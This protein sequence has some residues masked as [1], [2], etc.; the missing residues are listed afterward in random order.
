MTSLP[1]PAGQYHTPYV[2]H[3]DLHQAPTHHPVEHKLPR[4]CHTDYTQLVS[5]VRKWREQSL[6]IALEDSYLLTSQQKALKSVLL[7]FLLLVL[8]FS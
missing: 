4:K 1:S 5:K 2:A 3:P 6:T 7:V 8:R